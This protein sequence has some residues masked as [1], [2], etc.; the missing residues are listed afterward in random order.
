MQV[1]PS[2]SLVEI[3]PDRGAQ[4]LGVVL[5]IVLLAVMALAIV[6]RPPGPALPPGSSGGG[7]SVSTS[8]LRGEACEPAAEPGE[9]LETPA[10]T[11]GGPA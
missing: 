2:P 8:D 1:S 6:C 7:S 10:R 4:F 5:L 9:A 3:P 11:S